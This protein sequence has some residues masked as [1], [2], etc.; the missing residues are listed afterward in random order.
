MIEQIRFCMAK[1]DVRYYLNGMFLE[2]TPKYIRTVATDGHRLAMSTMLL[3]ECMSTLLCSIIISKQGILELLRLLTKSKNLIKVL[4][5][6]NTFRICTKK[7]LFTTKLID[8]TFPNYKNVL[9]EK[10]DVILKINVSKLKQV[11]LRVALLSDKQFRGV[12]F[13]INQKIVNT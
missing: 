3:N 4:I 12:E 1:D 10:V 8:G 13:D 9:L 11:L 5:S 2:I 7:F 6:N